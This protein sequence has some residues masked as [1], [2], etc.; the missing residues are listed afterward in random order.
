MTLTFEY[1]MNIGA[2]LYPQA[3]HSKDNLLRIFY[4]TPEHTVSGLIA[5]PV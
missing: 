2:G 4:L 5:D 1:T 3:I